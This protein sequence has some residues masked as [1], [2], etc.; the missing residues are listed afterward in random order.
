M[1]VVNSNVVDLALGIPIKSVLL[2]AGGKHHDSDSSL[3]QMEM[4]C[5]DHENEYS[6]YF[7]LVGRCDTLDE[8]HLMV[9]PLAENFSR[10]RVPIESYTK[11]LELLEIAI[12]SHP[13]V[14]HIIIA[15]W[16]YSLDEG[17]LITDNIFPSITQNTRIK[18]VTIDPGYLER[19]YSF[20]FF[21]D[22]LGCALIARERLDRLTFRFFDEGYAFKKFFEQFVD[23]PDKLPRIIRM[24]ECFLRAGDLW[25]LLED[26]IPS[27]SCSIEK[28]DVAKCYSSLYVKPSKPHWNIL[29]RNGERL[30]DYPLLTKLCYSLK[31]NES[32]HTLGLFFTFDIYRIV[33]DEIFR[34]NTVESAYM[35]N[36]HLCNIVW[37]K[38][39]PEGWMGSEY[40]S[41]FFVSVDNNGIDE[42][43]NTNEQPDLLSIFDE[44]GCDELL[45]GDYK[46]IM[47]ENME[48]NKLPN[49]KYV[50]CLKVL[51]LL[52]TKRFEECVLQ[53]TDAKLL[54]VH[55]GKFFDKARNYRA[56]ETGSELTNRKINFYYELARGSDLCSN[57]I[58]AK[59]RRSIRLK[60]KRE[61]NCACL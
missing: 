35:G 56:I 36:H 32:I 24:R 41:R 26:L 29:G 27:Q 37:H 19:E 14:N 8:I 50:A 11:E 55:G 22:A 49:K 18:N 51:R 31:Q 9:T 60:R 45:S 46:K 58:K 7:D 30:I 1:L 15:H 20:A 16:A 5:I 53:T 25:H 10:Q 6:K 2:R 38:A 39:E 23:N 48:L 52:D 12:A 61:N 40:C 33:A 43:G 4:K 13:S 3:R 28:L 54:A 42:N 17:H 59:L 34:A 44:R 47:D 57:V 21:L